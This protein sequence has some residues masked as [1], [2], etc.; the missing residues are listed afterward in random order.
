MRRVSAEQYDS[1]RVGQGLEIGTLAAMTNNQSSAVKFKSAPSNRVRM[2]KVL[3]WPGRPRINQFDSISRAF[4][5]SRCCVRPNGTPSHRST[6]PSCRSGQSPAPPAQSAH[7]RDPQIEDAVRV[8][9]RRPGLQAR[10]SGVRGERPASIGQNV[11]VTPSGNR[12]RTYVPS[13]SLRAG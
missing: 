12:T 10:P 5:I 11:G 8:C 6:V 13:P 7:V 1:E 3:P 4:T 2:T 9:L